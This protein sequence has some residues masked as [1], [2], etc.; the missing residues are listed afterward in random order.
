MRRISRFCSSNT[1]LFAMIMTLREMPALPQTFHIVSSERLLYKA[2]SGGSSVRPCPA[3][4][5]PDLLRL[6]PQ[7]KIKNTYL[8]RNGIQ[9]YLLIDQT[10]ES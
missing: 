3:Y 2:S 7:F 9:E 5:E 4:R 6:M 8:L 1:I 10:H